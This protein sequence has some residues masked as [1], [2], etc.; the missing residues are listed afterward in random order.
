MKIEKSVFEM[1]MKELNFM[2]AMLDSVGTPRQI[3]L[4][5]EE[6]MTQLSLSQRLGL[7]TM[8]REVTERAALNDHTNTTH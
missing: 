3:E 7:Y 5:G 1:T 2:H 6:G 8:S 4:E